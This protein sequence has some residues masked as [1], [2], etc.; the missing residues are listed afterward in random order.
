VSAI[1][2][3]AAELKL[4]YPQFCWAL[5]ADET[6]CCIRDTGHEGDCFPCED[7]PR[8]ALAESERPT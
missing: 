5:N 3:Y 4:E 1:A 8:E 6:R 7:Q 2:N